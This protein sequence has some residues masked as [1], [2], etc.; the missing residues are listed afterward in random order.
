MF[1][2][3][4]PHNQSI[5]FRVLTVHYSMASP[6]PSRHNPYTARVQEQGC[7]RESKPLAALGQGTDC[8]LSARTVD[9]MASRRSPPKVLSLALKFAAYPAV[10][11][12]LHQTL[13]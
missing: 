4:S 10:D 9:V 5:A 11:I 1:L 8:K 3:K 13:V 12:R 6:H 7:L 2:A